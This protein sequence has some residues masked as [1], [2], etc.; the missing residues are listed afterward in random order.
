MSINREHFR[1]GRAA[2]PMD[3]GHRLEPKFAMLGDG[4]VPCRWWHPDF[5]A[6]CARCGSARADLHDGVWDL[7]DYPPSP[8]AP[9]GTNKYE[10][11]PWSDRQRA[12]LG[13]PVAEQWWHQAAGIVVKP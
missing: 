10:G 12:N 6:Y 3:D 1:L 7:P 5:G 13:L 2:D 8:P 4:S 11:I 9:A